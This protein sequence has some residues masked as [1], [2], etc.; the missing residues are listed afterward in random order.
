MLSPPP[1]TPYLQLTLGP[2]LVQLPASPLQPARL[3]LGLVQVARRVLPALAHGLPAALV[4]RAAVP[5][6]RSLLV[7]QHTLRSQVVDWH[8]QP[9]EYLAD[10]YVLLSAVI[11]NKDRELSDVVRVLRLGLAPA[12][13]HNN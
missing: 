13:R 4:P 3:V 1:L 9:I 2:Y 8:W 7:H 5:V 6:H 10:I 12:G 11:L